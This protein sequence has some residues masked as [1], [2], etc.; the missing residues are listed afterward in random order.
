MHLEKLDAL[1]IAT[2]TKLGVRAVPPGEVHSR[3]SV[4]DAH[5]DGVHAVAFAS[6]KFRDRS[7]V[8][9]IGCSWRDNFDAA[10]PVEHD[11]E[12]DVGE[13]V[14]VKPESTRACETGI[15]WTPRTARLHRAAR[16]QRRTRRDASRQR[17]WHRISTLGQGGA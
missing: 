11:L 1:F 2:L 16:V 13:L 12:A 17:A 5:H 4:V 14:P 8:S 9:V 3:V 10:V 6:Q 7:G 15:Q